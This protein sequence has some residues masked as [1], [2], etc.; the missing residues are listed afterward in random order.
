MT[1][2]SRIPEI[3]IEQM[4][5]RH[6][7]TASPE[8]LS[9]RSDLINYS[10]YV[11]GFSPQPFHRRWLDALDDSAITRLL[12]IA[13]PDHAK[14]QYV[15]I[16]YPAF[17]IGT[18]P[19]I[20]IGLISNTATQANRK[21][22]AIKDTI[23][24]NQRFREVFPSIRPDKDKGWSESEWYIQR[25][26]PGDKDSTLKASG[27]YGPITGDRYG[28]MIFDDIADLENTATPH[29]RQ[30]LE[31]WIEVTAMH[32]LEPGGKAVAI[33]TRYHH[34]DI[35]SYF[36]TEGWTVIHMPALDE[37]NV[38]LWEE[39]HSAA[40]LMDDR[41]KHPFTF[42]RVQQGRPTAQE[43]ALIKEQWWRY[44][45]ELPP[46]IRII[47]V[48]DTAFKTQTL[49]DYSVIATW[50]L[51]QDGAYLID[52]EEGKWEYPELKRRTLTAYTRHQPSTVLIEDAASGQSLIQD[53]SETTL[54]PVK[55]VKPDR[56]KVSRIIAVLDYFASGRVWLPESAPWLGAFIQQ[57]SDF[58]LGEH[59][60]KVDTTAMAIT[61]LLTGTIAAEAVTERSGNQWE[62]Q[63]RTLWGRR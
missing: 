4:K 13:P 61:E 10:E 54:L 42:E 33:M 57:H 9:A 39:R 50:G 22:V 25:A 23:A 62:R 29:Q 46:M 48:L 52:V 18:N 7:I 6:G 28:L 51:G 34:A 47:Q 17:C 24:L 41:A 55:S 49:N 11:H 63:G 1:L 59:D 26:D 30:K 15:A 14:T 56:D 53:L 36:I 20:H 31:E 12:I 58:P 45:S 2:A 3:V 43:G 35:A 32:R 5:L 27:V 60:D 8:V 44:Y 19:N 21:S 40:E 38:A 16:E 37:N